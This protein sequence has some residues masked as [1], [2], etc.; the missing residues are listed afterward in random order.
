MFIGSPNGGVWRTSN[1]GATWLPLTDNQASL[2]I[3]SLALDPTDPTGKTLIAGIGVTSNGVWDAFNAPGRAGAG[4]LRTGLLYTTDGGAVWSPLGGAALDGLSVIGVAARGNDILAATFEE[5]NPTDAS[6]AYGLYR[7]TDGGKSFTKLGLGSGLPAGP[8]TALVGDTA[9]SMTLYAAITSPA[10]PTATTISVSKDG[11]ATWSPALT[12]ATM[13]AGGVNVIPTSPNQLVVKLA[14]GPNDSLAAAFV[15]AKTGMPVALYLS[16]NSGATWSA[17]A[18]PAG[19]NPGGQGIV[20]LSLAIDTANPSIVYIAGDRT[21]GPPYTVA[22]FRVEGLTDTSLTGPTFTANGST[23]HADSRV[24]VMNA[25]G[26]LVLG[27]DGGIYIRSDPET[28]SGGWQGLNTDTLEIR[29]PYA[30]AFGANSKRLAVA[31]QDTGVAIQSAPGSPVYFAI[32]GG[33]G[34]V[35]VVNDQTFPGRSAYYTSSQEF[36]SLSRLILDKQGNMVSPDVGSAGVPV[37]CNGGDCGTVVKGVQFSSPF[38]L[39]KIDQSRIAL[40]GSDVYVSQDTTPA[41]ANA[42]DLVLTDVGATGE[43][44]QTISYGTQDNPNALLVGTAGAGGHGLLFVSETS[45]P[46]S[47]TPASSLPA[48]EGQTPTSTVFDLRSQNRFYVAD[49]ADLWGTA[50]QGAIIDKLTGNLPANIVRPTSVEFINNNGVNALLTGGLSDVANAQS[51]IAVAD[52]NAAGVLSN[53]RLFGNG[54]PNALVWQM[55]YNPLADVLSIVSVGRGVY[56]LYD[57]TSNFPQ[58]TVLQFGLADNNSMP[59]ASILTNGTVGDRPLIKYGSGTLV[60]AGEA[61]YTGGTTINEGVLQLGVGGADGSILGDVADF[62]ALVFDRSDVYSFDG[63]ISGTGSVVQEGSGV[64]V[65]TAASPLT[66]PTFVNAGALVVNGAIADSPV[67]VANGGTLGGYGAVGGIIAQSGGMVA[68]GLLQPFSTLNVNGNVS[69][70]P[71]SVFAVNVNWQGQK[72]MLFATGAASLSGGIVQVLAS[73]GVYSPASRYD[74]LT[75]L[76]GVTGQFDSLETSSNLAEA[77]AFLTPSLTYDANDVLLGFTQTASFPSVATTRNQFSTATALEGLDPTGPLFN[78]VIGQSVSG[79]QQAFDALSGEVHASAVTAAFEDSRLPREA[80]LDRLDQM[81]D[82]SSPG[83]DSN[84]VGVHSAGSPPGNHPDFAL[85]RAQAPEPHLSGFWG[86]GFGYWGENRSD[87]NAA[88]LSRS[89]GGFVL[90]AD[91]P[92]AGWGGLWRIGFAAGYTD[93][94]ITVGQRQSSGGFQSIFGAAYGGASFGAVQLRAGAI[95][96]SDITSTNRQIA[97]PNFADAV[98][99]QYGGETGQVFAEAGYRVPLAWRSAFRQAWLE[100]VIGVA[101]IQIR[102]DPFAESGGVAAL[103]GFGRAYDFAAGTVGLRAATTIGG[104]LP[105]TL[106]GFVGWRS[107]FGDLT[108]AALLAFQGGAEAFSVTG[109]PIDRNAVVVEAGVNYAVANAVTLGI[110]YSGQ[111]GQRATDN[112]FQAHLNVSF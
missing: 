75:A 77:F 3:A 83:P 20:N 92:I 71:G 23:A 59:D 11:G 105:L 48:Y 27:G 108:P 5:Q 93:D 60:I 14:S 111:F 69:F 34:V 15:D 30:V 21:S 103:S 87:G 7:S 55:S 99:S 68:P 90:G 100:P 82:P 56:T 12:S 4:G 91:A 106:R 2:S 51:P 58:A 67:T 38:V 110:S 22:A 41:A 9:N 85:A 89:T 36:G 10:S 63:S 13:I 66:G 39:N 84:L 80:I 50:D 8:V 29:E 98:S 94:A 28:T 31:A 88:S 19:L 49:G 25:A 1:D 46:S 17:L 44:I 101:G 109:A 64:T 16:Q 97:F 62:G 79:A 42:V 18:V 107:A 74:I 76:G 47:I 52:S 112:A 57:V 45:A 73:T 86:Q 33:D 72:D 54:L 96:G 102:E 81:F 104:S 35:A 26:N 32:Q 37:L 24:L 78:A 40:G 61:T 6:P 43:Q 53:W 70:A 95:Y 65:L